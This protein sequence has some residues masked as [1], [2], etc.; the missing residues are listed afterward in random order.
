MH[1]RSAHSPLK[2]LVVED[3]DDAR[4]LATHALSRLGHIV[5]GISSGAG[6]DSE[7]VEFDADLLL[8]DVSLP[9]E[10]GLSIARRMRQDRPNI[11][12][13]MLTAHNR[14]DD[15]VAGYASGA[16]IYLIKPVSMRE[17]GAATEA[18]ARRLHRS[19]P[20]APPLSLHPTLRQLTGPLGTVDISKRESDLLRAFLDSN[21][22]VLHNHS[23]QSMLAKA[24]DTY[25]KATLE[26]QIVR[27][28]K[29][30]ELA[31][32]TS[33]TLKAIRGIGY[34]LCVPLEV[35]GTFTT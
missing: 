25:S 28:R 32:A 9:G 18:V 20:A 8:L 34:Q 5:H 10:D 1:T 31:G 7:L 11:G 6:V 17:L 4:L 27:L 12:I 29:K 14:V 24:D 21:E 30:L 13:I 3:N 19:A 35:I 2:I 16:D 33:P 15:K 22:R 23:I 26:V